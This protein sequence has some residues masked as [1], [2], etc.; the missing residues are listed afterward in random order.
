MTKRALIVGAGIAGQTLACALAK[1]EYQIDIVEKSLS[2]EVLGT[3]MYVQN[4]A[5][6]G[7][8]EIGVAEQIVKAGWHSPTGV[9][10]ITDMHGN[11]LAQTVV[12]PCPGSDFPG[13]VPI[14]RP[15]LHA[16]LL[17]AVEAA[18]VTI[19]MGKSVT[20]ISQSG[21]RVDVSFTDGA[22]ASY[23][24][25]IGADGV[26]SSVRSLVF[27]EI[28]PQYSGFSNW[29]A[30]LPMATP[31]DD[32]MWQMGPEKS[33]GI[34]PI[35]DDELYIAGVSKEPGNPWFEPETLV[36]RMHE[37]FAMFGGRA[38]GLLK[39]ITRSEQIVYTPIKEII[40]EPPWFKG[41]VVLVGDAAHAS[42][43][44]WA[45][46]ASMA[47]EDVIV[48]YWLLRENRDVPDIFSEWQERRFERCAFVQNGSKSTGVNGHA[49]GL[50]AMNRAAEHIRN[51]AQ[52]NV[53]SR[54]E[55][56]N[57]PI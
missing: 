19:Q 11:T 41:R 22:R 33:V 26:N 10:T 57:Q 9:S 49:A 34:I 52:D 20:G 12:P 24:I 56:L 6:R 46:G 37:R 1:T 53:N 17:A 25:V 48:L 50:E 35:S 15:V 29:R 38:G 55:R 42:T 23:D 3:G 30:I 28:E 32:T 51:H 44:F 7:F 18:G 21:D 14:G 16:I 27:A 54:Y 13:Y 47:I 39:Q 8:Q 5:L 43:P 36:R 40:M 45:Q 2:W 4:N 31:L